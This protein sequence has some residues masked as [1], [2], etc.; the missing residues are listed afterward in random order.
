MTGM[1]AGDVCS[2][3]YEFSRCGLLD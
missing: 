1:L 2:S 3:A